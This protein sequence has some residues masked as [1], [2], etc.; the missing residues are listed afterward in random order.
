MDTPDKKKDVLI[1]EDL[2]GFQSLHAR[3]KESELW[4]TYDRDG[5]IAKP[6]LFVDVISMPFKS[7]EEI[8][9]IVR[10]GKFIFYF[11]WN[12]DIKD[13]K[14]KFRVI[15]HYSD[16]YFFVNENLIYMADAIKL[17]RNEVD[18]IKTLDF[19]KMVEYNLEQYKPVIQEYP[20]EHEQVKLSVPLPH[21]T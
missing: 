7:F 12:Y 11:K 20:H 19:M 4:L 6:V 21:E 16:Q 1:R 18:S 13:E 5:K 14:R 10:S 17:F 3:T 15:E 2:I 8:P 9:S